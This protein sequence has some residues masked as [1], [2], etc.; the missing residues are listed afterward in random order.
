MLRSHLRLLF[1]YVDMPAVLAILIGCVAWATFFPARIFNVLILCGWAFISAGLFSQVSY[2]ANGAFLRTRPGWRNFRT[3]L[4]I[5]HLLLAAAA[6]A[7][8]GLVHLTGLDRMALESLRSFAG[9]YRLMEKEVLRSWHW[10]LLPFSLAAAAAFRCLLEG[11]GRYAVLFGIAAAL[12]PS[13]PVDRA[14]L[15]WWESQPPAVWIAAGAAIAVAW[16]FRRWKVS[17]GNASVAV[18]RILNPCAR[19]LGGFG[20]GTRTSGAIVLLCWLCFLLSFSPVLQG[21]FVWRHAHVTIA[22]CA[23]AAGCITLWGLWA[24]RIPPYWLSRPSHSGGGVVH[25][26]RRLH[27]SAHE[28]CLI[29]GALLG[30]VACMHTV[31]GLAAATSIAGFLNGLATASLAWMFFSVTAWALPREG[32]IEGVV[33]GI[34][35]IVAAVNVPPLWAEVL[36]IAAPGLLWMVPLPPLIAA[37]LTWRT[38]AHVPPGTVPNGI[39]A[40][41]FL[42]LIAFACVPLAWREHTPVSNAL[43]VFFYSISH[44]GRGLVALIAL[45]I[46]GLWQTRREARVGRRSPRMTA[47]ATALSCIIPFAGVFL[48][49]LT[50]SRAS[51]LAVARTPADSLLFK[52]AFPALVAAVVLALPVGSRWDEIA[53]AKFLHDYSAGGIL[54]LHRVPPGLA[55]LAVQPAPARLRFRGEEIPNPWILPAAD[56]RARFRHPED[57]VELTRMLREG[58]A[59]EPVAPPYSAT[60]T[61]ECHVPVRASPRLFVQFAV[62]SPHPSDGPDAGALVETILQ[63]NHT[64]AAAAAALDRE[65]GANA[66]WALV[67]RAHALA[68]SAGD[69]TADLPGAGADDSMLELRA[70]AMRIVAQRAGLN[71]PPVTRCREYGTLLSTDSAPVPEVYR[72]FIRAYALLEARR[73]VEPFIDAVIRR[74]NADYI[75]GRSASPSLRRILDL[76]DSQALEKSSKAFS[77]S[78][79]EQLFALRWLVYNEPDI[80]K[81]DDRGLLAMATVP[82]K[83]CLLDRKWRFM[84][85]IIRLLPTPGVPPEFTRLNMTL[86]LSIFDERTVTEIVAYPDVEILTLLDMHRKKLTDPQ[87]APFFRRLTAALRERRP[88]D[89]AVA[90]WYAEAHGEGE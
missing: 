79:K 13:F 26:Y 75:L 8:I 87:H 81:D 3:T 33:L 89:E 23:A 59:F 17:A 64:P 43:S 28:S 51:R 82:Q 29:L 42:G 54:T 18:R 27:R 5:A 24:M 44:A 70:G 19:L 65:F 37:L 9:N 77:S 32:S 45:G 73:A 90:R 49:D 39:R 66:P 6:C 41:W 88:D 63:A 58:L 86:D 7:F 35:G 38:I 69:G 53:A 30:A 84:G 62:E 80:L 67:R 36:D 57:R 11:A 56:A 16:S 74:L 48:L 76:L 40:A 2:G 71:L 25:G 4:W 22:V 72:T 15:W 55:W 46:A 61:V 10:T 12:M 52:M 20:L 14:E 78:R 34:L 83:R 85:T 31:P 60:Y 21:V 47:A 50:R 68:G 1:T